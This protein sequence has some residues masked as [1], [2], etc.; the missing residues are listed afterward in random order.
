MLTTCMSCDSTQDLESAD[1]EGWQS[2][3]LTS[4]ADQPS[5]LIRIVIKG[6]G[7]GAPGFEILDANFLGEEF[8][9][10]ADDT[11]TVSS[12][13]CRAGCPMLWDRYSVPFLCSEI[14]VVRKSMC[15]CMWT[16]AA[17]EVADA[18]SFLVATIEGC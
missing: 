3:D 10:P 14:C 18:L 13:S 1:Q 7:S 15:L 16:M 17:E 2:F 6:T 4:F 11:I 12:R 8:A 5:D 9:V